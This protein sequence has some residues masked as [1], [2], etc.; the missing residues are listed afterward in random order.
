MLPPNVRISA[1][2]FSPDGKWLSFLVN[3][4]NGIELWMADTASAKARA[5]T[6]ATIN[7]LD[8]CGWLQ[9][10]SA[11][12]CHFVVDRPRAGAGAAG[13]ADGPAHPGEP[14][15]GRAGGHLSRTC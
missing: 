2:G 10:S 5:V 4:A 6:A 14:R 3:R 1:P 12:L 11:M 15:Q 8:G 9:D 13:R 7:G